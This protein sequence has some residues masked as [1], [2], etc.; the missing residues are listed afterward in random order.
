MLR[1]TALAAAVLL[2]AGCTTKGIVAEGAHWE[3]V[4]R[5]GRGD[6]ASGLYANSALPW[7][8]WRLQTQRK[9]FYFE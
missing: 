6:D 4:S 8:L 1:L 9:G 7:R 3:E 2:A 5:S